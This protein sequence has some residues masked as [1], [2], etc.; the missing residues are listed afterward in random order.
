METNEEKKSAESKSNSTRCEWAV[1]S[2]LALIIVF[3]GVWLYK[4]SDVLKSQPGHVE[5]RHV[6]A[7]FESETKRDKNEET[8]YTLYKQA[9]ESFRE[10]VNTWLTVIG[11]FGTLFGLIVPLASYLLQRHSLSE[12]RERI[13]KE[14][15]KEARDAAKG[16]AKDAADAKKAAEN[17]AKGVAKDATDAKKAANNAADEAKK[18]VSNVENAKKEMKEKLDTIQADLKEIGRIRDEIEETRGMIDADRKTIEQVKLTVQQATAKLDEVKG[19]ATKATKAV[20]TLSEAMTKGREEEGAAESE[21]E[22]VRQQA[23]QGDAMAQNSLGWKFRLGE[24]VEKDEFEAVYWYRKAANQG[25]DVAQYNLGLA[26]DF[27]RGID[28]NETKAVYWYRQAAEQGNADAENNLAVMIEYGTGCE[29]DD[30]G[31]LELYHKA[32]EHGSDMGRVNLGRV[33]E[34]GMLGVEKDLLKAKELYLQVVDD[35]NADEKPKK[36]AREGLDRIAKLEGEK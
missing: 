19:E 1:I 22:K 34:N 29:K 8:Q 14:M 5:V 32:V 16:A 28:K 25:L 20:Q 4:M 21:F 2:L 6:Y 10:L 33:Y 7:N 18:A 11:F 26:Y 13:M 9:E 23:E 12:E 15:R 24:G 27:G 36:L 17:A 31:A 3:S 35:P 30:K